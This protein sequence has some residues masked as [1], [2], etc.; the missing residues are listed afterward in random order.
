MKYVKPKAKDS[1]VADWEFGD[2]TKLS[3]ARKKARKKGKEKAMPIK[4]RRLLSGKKLPS[5]EVKSVE[6]IKGEFAEEVF[7]LLFCY[8]ASF[9]CTL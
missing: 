4:K 7:N 9:V 1:T 2:R 3:T 6:E 8:M 5:L